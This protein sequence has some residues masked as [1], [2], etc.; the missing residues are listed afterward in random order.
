MVG[1][2]CGR[3]GQGPVGTWAEPVGRAGGAG[4]VESGT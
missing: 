4:G 3:G 1:G 2:T